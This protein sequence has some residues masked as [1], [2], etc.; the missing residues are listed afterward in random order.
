MHADRSSESS[1]TKNSKAKGKGLSLSE[2]KETD[3]G[4]ELDV[5]RSKANKSSE[6]RLVQVAVL[7]EGHILHD[8]RQLVV[9]PNQDDS[10]QPTNTILLPLQASDWRSMV[11]HAPL[12]TLDATM[13]TR[14]PGFL[15]RLG[16]KF[17]QIPPMSQVKTEKIGLLLLLYAG[18][19]QKAG[20][21]VAYKTC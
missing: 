14:H 17:G 15:A 6:E 16:G 3:L 9:I 1:K 13:L 21:S 18:R 19:L 10:L 12:D 8:R 20:N 7:L 4:V 5:R 2:R 11:C